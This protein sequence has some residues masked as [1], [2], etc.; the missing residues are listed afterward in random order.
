MYFV[1]GVII[2]DR[3]RQVHHRFVEWGVMLPKYKSSATLIPVDLSVGNVLAHDITE[4]R[5]G[6][7]KGVA[8]KKGHVI[9]E[10]DIEHLKRLGKEH[11]FALSIKPGEVHENEAAIRLATALAGPGVV[12]DPEPAEGK[13]ALSAAFKGLLKVNIAALIRFNMVPDV[14]CA[15]KHNHRVVDAGEKIA[16]TRAI[17]TSG[18]VFI[19]EAPQHFPPIFQRYTPAPMASMIGS[20][21]RGSSGLSKT[22]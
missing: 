22:I 15:S 6:Q 18:F 13:I 8:F 9:R 16:A 1:A 3:F 14:T 10:E 2:E 11:I 5:P 7:F 20:M 21:D 12:F 19:C 4:I 17:P